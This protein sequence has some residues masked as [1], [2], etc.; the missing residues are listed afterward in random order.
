MKFL[1]AF[2]ILSLSS[3]SSADPC[4]KKRSIAKKLEDL[5]PSI[6]V[7]CEAKDKIIDSSKEQIRLEKKPAAQEQGRLESS[8]QWKKT[9]ERS[10]ELPPELRDSLTD[11]AIIPTI[12]KVSDQ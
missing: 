1:F 9:Y 11:Q 3:H 10:A 4:S 5:K 12:P 2:I 8:I 7:P 6:D